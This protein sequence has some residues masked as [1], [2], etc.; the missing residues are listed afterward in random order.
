MERIKLIWDFKGPNAARIA[1]H[2]SIHLDDFIKAEGLQNA[3]SAVEKISETHHI[4]YLV[5]KKEL[6]TELR[7]RLKP[8]RGQLHTP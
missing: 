6:M 4:A 5:V 1:Q 7:E 3:F 8:N 2:H